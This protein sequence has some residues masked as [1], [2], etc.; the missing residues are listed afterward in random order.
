M[1]ALTTDL[2]FVFATSFFA[3]LFDLL[4]ETMLS[5]S[6]IVAQRLWQDGLIFLVFRDP[7]Q[8]WQA[9]TSMATTLTD[10]EFGFETS[11]CV[12][13]FDFSTETTLL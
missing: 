10:L 8:S 6:W 3:H 2:E 7:F 4:T 1:A 5:P 13:L 11:C 9:L 12:P